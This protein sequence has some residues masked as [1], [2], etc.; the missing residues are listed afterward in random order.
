MSRTVGERIL[1]GAMIVVVGLVIFILHAGIGV[2]RDQDNGQVRMTVDPTVLPVV[3][4]DGSESPASS[5]TLDPDTANATEV[6]EDTEPPATPAPEETPQ[7]QAP[8][9]PEST[10][11]TKPAS[12][13]GA[14][15]GTVQSVTLENTATGFTI[16]VTANAP[17]GDTSYMNLSGPH[18]LVVDLRENKT[19]K[20]KNVVRVADGPVKHV[21][22]GEHPDRLRLVVHFRTP[23]ATRLTPQFTRTG[24]TLKI[25]VPLQ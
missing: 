16:T 13:T 22:V 5:A 17:I 18:R 24:N 12:P 6:A 20:A 19:S 3:L 8:P 1:F 15:A 9:A 25:T 14:N 4:P 10:P 7:A 23:P 21:V 11:E 2:T